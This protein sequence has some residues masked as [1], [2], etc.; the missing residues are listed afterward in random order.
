MGRFSLKRLAKQMV[1]PGSPDVQ[2]VTGP[3]PEW[4]A[5]AAAHGFEY[6]LDGSELAGL[7][8]E[9]PPDRPGLGEQYYNVVRGTWNGAPFTY[10][11]HKTWNPGGPNGRAP[12]F[13]GALVIQLP[14]APRADL[15]TM[16]P[17]KAFKAAGGELPRSG[18]WE[19]KAPDLLVGWGAWLD[20]VAIEGHLQR[21]SMQLAVAPAELWQN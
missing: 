13:A 19:W 3:D 5:W 4:Q 8:R 21:I 16:G 15:V 12:Q 11:T 2:H 10:V 1:Q 9:L 17:D 7:Y 14:G 6:D 18:S 20:P